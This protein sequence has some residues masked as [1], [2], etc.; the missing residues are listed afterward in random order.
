MSRY[1]RASLAPRNYA[2]GNWPMTGHQGRNEGFLK[3]PRNTSE[4]ISFRSKFCN[5]E[6]DLLGDSEILG[7]LDNANAAPS[8]H[9]AEYIGK[10][11]PHLLLSLATCPRLASSIDSGRKAFSRPPPSSASLGLRFP[12]TFRLCEA[13]FSHTP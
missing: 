4:I 13:A 11:F 10:C 2:A 9:I 1:L 7:Y 6:I 5:V 12:A 8:K 3:K